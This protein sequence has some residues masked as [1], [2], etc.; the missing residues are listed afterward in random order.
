VKHTLRIF[1]I[2]TL[3]LTLLPACGQPSG[4]GAVSGQIKFLEAEGTVRN[5]PG[6]QV[7][8]RGAQDTYTAVSTAG[9]GNDPD[10]GYNYR[11]DSVPPGRYVMAITPP[12]GLGLQPEDELQ[13][14]VEADE[15]YAQSA[16]LLPEGVA[17]PR[18]LSPEEAGNGQVGYSHNGQNRTYS[19]G[20]LDMSDYLLMYLLFRN[21]GGYGYGVPPV[22]ISNPGSSSPSGSRYRV[23]PP[24]T[25]T[26]RGDRITQA[27]RGVPG[28][29]ATRP[30]S[31]SSGS[32]SQPRTSSGSS[33]NQPTV[34]TPSQG[35]SRPSAPAPSRSTGRSSGGSSG[36]RK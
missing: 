24:P 1:F 2:V 32:S 29:G 12:A 9:E 20:G 36:G 10:A 15:T 5:L 16:L 6:A 31:S 4:P 34:K 8:L 17:K 33:S 11:I 28:Q 13:L 18:P 21:P 30:G 27:P 35:A 26:S 25:Q 14:E 19:S 3:L 23:E 7:I 22:V